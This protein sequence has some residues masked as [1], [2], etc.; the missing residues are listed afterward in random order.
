MA[1][2]S[3]VYDSYAQAESA[4]RD[5]EAA[6]VPSEDISLVA[7]KYVSEQ[8][9]DVNEASATSTGIGLGAAAG[10]GAGLLAGL[11]LLA[12]PGLGPVVAAGWFAATA[13]G[14][15]AGAATGGII[16]AL[17]DAG[18]SEPDAHVYSEAVRRGGTLLTVRTSSASAD[19]ID[20]ILNQYDPIDPTRRRQEY[21]QAGWREF[22]PSAEPY[23]PSQAELDRIRRR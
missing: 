19:T 6:G 16:G 5:L 4:V 14:A 10:G 3:K 22:D 18:T 12:I 20:R 1:V 9:A 15:A 2:Y 8:Y 11:G 7:N 17:V 21:E 23:T 13:A